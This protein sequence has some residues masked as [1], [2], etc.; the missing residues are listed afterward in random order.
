MFCVARVGAQVRFHCKNFT[1]SI[2]ASDWASRR[3]DRWNRAAHL[4]AR[5]HAP[6]EV[7]GIMMTMSAHH[8][9]LQMVNSGI[10]TAA[11]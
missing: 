4:Y 6:G 2:P 1:L 11:H 10:G 5:V 7:C 3:L 9:V 8:S